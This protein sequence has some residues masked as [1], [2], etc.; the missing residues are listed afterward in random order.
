VGD[1]RMRAVTRAGRQTALTVATA[2]SGRATGIP[3]M[4]RVGADVV[5][6]WRQG[7]VKTARVTV[8]AP[9]ATRR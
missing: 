8:P 7:T 3:M 1:V 2:S 9:E 4:A 6:A 5:V